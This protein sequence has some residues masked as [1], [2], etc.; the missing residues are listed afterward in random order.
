MQTSGSH[1]TPFGTRARI[2]FVALLAVALSLLAGCSGSSSPN[3]STPTTQNPGPGVTLETIKITPSNSS[4]PLAA[5]RQLFATGIYNDGSSVDITSQVTWS[6]SSQPS[7][8]NFVT[9]N[10]SGVATASS[11]GTTVI[12]ATVGP[13]VGV[14]Q[15]VVDTNGFTSSTMAVLTVPFKTSQID[16]GYLPLQSQIQGAYA[17]QEVNLDAD[18]FSSVLPVPLAL[19]AS[20]PMPA[21]FIPNATAASQNTSKVAVISYS[22]PNVQIIDGSNDPLD[23]NSNTLVATFTAPVSQSVTINGI[24]CIICAAVVN[25]LN[26]QL[27]LSTAQ[28]FYSMDM[29]SGKFTAMPFTPAP[30]PAAN[31]S[32]DPGAASPYI[33][34]TSPGNFAVQILNLATNAVTTYNSVTPAPATAFV[35]L[36]TNQTAIVDSSANDYAL[37]DLSDPANPQFL[38]SSGLGVCP[39]G[40]NFLNMVAIG[41]PFLA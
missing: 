24:S 19:K 12:S 2:L 40:S 31:F 20:I 7:T 18:Q 28:G 37:A 27:V 8:T 34:S 39:G 26:D 1:S 38:P 17:V 30:F 14:L 6:A 21:G 41:V 33:L 13:V 36:I 10:S 35:D 4:I 3:Y 11:V 25:P 5:S 16:V 22:S 15:M 32:I 23:L 9:V 29:T